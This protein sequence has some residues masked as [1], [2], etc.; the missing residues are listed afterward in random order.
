[1]FKERKDHER[2]SFDRKVT[3]LAFSHVQKMG[4]PEAKESEQFKFL[5]NLLS[6]KG[7]S[8]HRALLDFGIFEDFVDKVLLVPSCEYLFSLVQK[9][10][11]IQVLNALTFEGLRKLAF[12]E[13]ADRPDIRKFF[14]WVFKAAWD[15]KCDNEGKISSFFTENKLLS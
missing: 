4:G 1:M 14:D 10:S 2:Y 15:E 8:Y 12:F 11:I 5:M 6:I 13:D 3:N 9:Y 7:K